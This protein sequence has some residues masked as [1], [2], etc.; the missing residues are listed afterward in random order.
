[1]SNVSNM[2]N[3][4]APITEKFDP[5]NSEIYG[6]LGKEIAKLGG[7]GNHMILYG[8]GIKVVYV[9]EEHG[10]TC[11]G[12]VTKYMMIPRHRILGFTLESA[13]RFKCSRNIFCFFC[14][15]FSCC[16]CCHFE[17]TGIVLKLHRKNGFERILIRQDWDQND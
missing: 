4:P 15:C 5:N 2:S 8:G 13:S 9:E 7:G 12:V 10:C 16:R 11:C 1:M 17:Y 3:P 6:D 14:C